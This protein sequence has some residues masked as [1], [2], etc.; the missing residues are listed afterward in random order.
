MY[1]RIETVAGHMEQVI[2]HNIAPADF[3]FEAFYFRYR[4]ALAAIVLVIIILTFMLLAPFLPLFHFQRI[5]KN[6]LE[7]GFFLYRLQVV[8]YIMMVLMP[9]ADDLSCC[10]VRKAAISMPHQLLVAG[11]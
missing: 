2:P 9:V 8:V 4:S 3:V 7:K 11:C 1:R 10:H 5:R 6:N